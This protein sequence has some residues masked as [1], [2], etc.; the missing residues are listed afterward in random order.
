MGWGCCLK[1]VYLYNL[2]ELNVSL[3]RALSLLQLTNRIDAEYGALSPELQRAARWVR[4][5]PTQL[6]LQSMRQSAKAAGVA[7]ATF[8]RLAQALGLGGFEGMRAPVIAHLSNASRQSTPLTEGATS[9][10]FK[11][12]ISALLQAQ[13]AN[14]ASIE[15]NASSELV[16]AARAILNA[17]A[18]LFIGMRASH[19][20]AHQMRYTCDWLRPDTVLA[21]D[22]GGGWSDQVNDLGQQD[23]LVAVSQAPY[24]RHVVEVVQ[25]CQARGVPVLALTDNKLSPLAMAAN[26]ALFFGVESPAFFHSMTG[27]LALAEALMNEVAAQGGEK[28]AERL[29]AR[30]ERHR[31]ARTYWQRSY[32]K[33][34]APA[35]KPPA[36]PR[37]PGSSI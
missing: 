7:P 25:Q 3:N 12:E 34:A 20:I 17:R 2:C 36:S 14:V 24:T 33:L 13:A 1:H 9:G 21:S 23:L 18:V 37:N 10:A 5:H 29:V 6:G 16:A 35:L 31:E 26:W 8:S 27:A 30:Q 11:P 15:R 19:G 28:V 32:R 4:E 22:A